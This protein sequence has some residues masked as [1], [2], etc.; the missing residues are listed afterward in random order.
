MTGDKFLIFC[1]S[2]LDLRRI[3]SPNTDYIAG[4]QRSYPWVKLNTLPGTELMP[5]LLTGTYPHENGIWQVKL[6]ANS[7]GVSGNSLLDNLPDIVTTTYQCIIHLMTGDFDLASIPSRRLR[8]FEQ[9]RFKYT[10]REKS[11]RLPSIIGGVESIFSILGSENSSY[12][13]SRKFSDLDKLLSKL[14]TGKH[15]LEFFE[16]YGLDLLQHWSL[17]DVEKVISAYRAVD[18]F[19][20]KLH[21]KCQH[22]GITLA[23]L[24]SHGQEQIRGDVDIKG[25][26]KKLDLSEKEYASYIE[27][28]MARFW[29]HTDRARRRI[30]DMLFSLKHGTVLSYQD[31]HNHNIKFNDN[32]YGEL[33]FIADPGYIIYPHDF[34]HPLANIYLGLESWE[35]RN[36]VFNPHHRGCHGYLPHHESERGFMMVVEDHY[37]V[38]ERE[39]DIID[40]APSI[41]GLMGYK[42]ADSMRGNYLFN[43]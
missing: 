16:F 10:R 5:T 12:V 1:S 31:M 40:V 14:G 41:L 3:H 15:R 2:S 9:R 8:L 4:L 29:F 34:Y 36:R 19:V 27:V 17:G 11:G 23:I 24:S 22:Q 43:A 13:F 7:N 30:T 33:Y 32:K 28:P 25:A 38:N 20:R 37:K 35:Q 42:K 26:L 6:N 21:E 18:H 39:A